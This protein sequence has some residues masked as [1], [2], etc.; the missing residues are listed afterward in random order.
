MYCIIQTFAKRNFK[1]FLAM[2]IQFQ[3]AQSVTDVQ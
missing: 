2:L 3:S 1:T